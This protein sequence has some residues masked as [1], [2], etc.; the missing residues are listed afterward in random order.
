MATLDCL[1]CIMQFFCLEQLK[2]L[3]ILCGVAATLACSG[4]AA[5]T[6][7]RLIRCLTLVSR[8]ALTKAVMQGAGVLLF[9]A[10]AAIPTPT[11]T[12]QH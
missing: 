8:Y 7:Y 1:L 4:S 2:S 10:K 11:G 9:H 3:F 12:A 5:A 6:P